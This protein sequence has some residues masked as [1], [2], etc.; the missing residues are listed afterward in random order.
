MANTKNVKLSR[1][2]NFRDNLRRIFA[3]GVSQVATARNAGIHPVHLA[4]ILSGKAS[5]VTIET[6]ES[7]SVSLEI[8]LETLLSRSPSDTDLRIFPKKSES[9]A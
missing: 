3:A 8:P 4:K 5:N 6:A 1:G 2:D 7:L 9:V